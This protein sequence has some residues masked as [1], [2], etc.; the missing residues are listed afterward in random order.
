M[1][2]SLNPSHRW[3]LPILFLS[4]MQQSPTHKT[5]D[6]LHTHVAM[7]KLWFALDFVFVYC[8]ARFFAAKEE[9]CRFAQCNVFATCS[10]FLFT[11]WCDLILLNLF[12][13]SLHTHCVFVGRLSMCSLRVAVFIGLWH[14]HHAI[15]IIVCS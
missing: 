2:S 8:W 14:T 6:F 12:F 9:C 3:S 11:S 15:V 5:L 4:N 10:W 1:S 13:T 7:C